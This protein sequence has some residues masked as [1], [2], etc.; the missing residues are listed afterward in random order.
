[1]SVELSRYIESECHPT[2][3]AAHYWTCAVLWV[4]TSFVP[5]ITTPDAVVR[6]DSRSCPGIFRQEH[7]LRA[8]S[9]VKHSV[10]PGG[11]GWHCPLSDASHIFCSPLARNDILHPSS[12]H[13]L[14][15]M[16]KLAREEMLTVLKA[17]GVEVPATTKIPDDDLNKRVRDALNAAQ[18]KDKLPSPL[19]LSDLPP[20]P[21]SDQERSLFEAV[22]RGTVGEA[23]Q[24]YITGRRQPEL[25]VDAFM[26]L[27]QSTMHLARFVDGGA[28]CFIMKDKAGDQCAINIRVRALCFVAFVIS[29]FCRYCRCWRSTNGLR[30]SSSCIGSSRATRPTRAL[31]GSTRWSTSLRTKNR[32]CP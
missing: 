14:P 21:T 11:T 7:D 32:T 25:Y 23:V 3:A 17:M 24:N 9:R 18:Y 30:Q 15:P 27:R 2:K 12:F 13:H 10:A 26:D 8:W 20:W 31:T 1:M 22:Q 6:I 28:M 29:L 16:S 5:L 19:N 4:S